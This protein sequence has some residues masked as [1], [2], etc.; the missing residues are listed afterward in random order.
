MHLKDK[1]IRRMKDRHALHSILQAVLLGAPVLV[2]PV[3]MIDGRELCQSFGQG[4]CM[5]YFKAD[6][7]KWLLG[8]AHEVAFRALHLR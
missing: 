2:A 7:Q 5:C 1:H 6:V 4:V 8:A 3:Q